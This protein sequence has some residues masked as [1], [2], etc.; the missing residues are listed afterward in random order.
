MKIRAVKTHLKQTTKHENVNET[1]A[2]K[3]RWIFN[4]FLCFLIS[5]TQYILLGPQ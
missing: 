4:W 5:G 2:Q 1:L 3:K